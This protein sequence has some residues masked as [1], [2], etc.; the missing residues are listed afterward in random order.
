MECPIK[1]IIKWE[2]KEKWE[3]RADCKVKAIPSVTD[4]IG[5]GMKCFKE[6]VKILVENKKE[7]EQ[8]ISDCNTG[9]RNNI[10][11]VLSGLSTWDIFK[12]AYKNWKL[13]SFPCKWSM[14]SK[15]QSI[16][17]HCHFLGAFRIWGLNLEFQ[18]SF[19]N[20]QICQWSLAFFLFVSIG[21]F[22]EFCYWEILVWSSTKLY[23]TRTLWYALMQNPLCKA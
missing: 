18:I 11:K 13:V 6:D 5:G 23:Y 10:E 9:M 15:F 20:Q 3:T 7:V 22:S 1:Q 8:T 14:I 12:K 16:D 19:S 17:F 4:C 2:K 21:F